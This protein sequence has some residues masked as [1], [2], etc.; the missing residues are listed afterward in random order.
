M[1]DEKPTPPVD[2]RDTNKTVIADYRAQSGDV[3]DRAPL[4]LLTTIGAK[5]GNPHTTPVCVGTDGDDLIVAGSMGGRSR[6]P[7]WYRNLVADPEL[8]VEYMG[9]K[10]QARATTVS[11]SAERDGL[12]AQM[13]QYI[14]GLYGYQDR[15]RE[16]RQ[17]PIV[18]L[19]RA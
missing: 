10:Y 18:R 5:S 4:V 11:N 6:H 14:Q 9:D 8:T 16:H 15:C 7:Q 3:G 13:S 12:F 19:Q 1:A 17:I 2:I